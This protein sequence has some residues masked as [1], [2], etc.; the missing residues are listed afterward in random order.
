MAVWSRRSEQPQGLVHH[1]D[2]GVPRL[3]VHHTN[4]LALAGSFSGPHRTAL[5]REGGPRRGVE[6]GEHSAM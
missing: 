6:D 1:S 5:V 2:R 3:A 4:C